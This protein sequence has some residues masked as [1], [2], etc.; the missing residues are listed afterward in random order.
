[1][2]I[3]L[4]KINGWYHAVDRKPNSANLLAKF[5]TDDVGNVSFFD[6]NYRFYFIPYII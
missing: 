2:L 3:I 5:L 4:H 6:R 1:M